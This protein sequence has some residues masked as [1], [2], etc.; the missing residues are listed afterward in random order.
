MASARSG[1][2]RAEAHSYQDLMFSLKAFMLYTLTAFT[3][4][5]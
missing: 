4:G 2:G 5:L 3:L 1:W